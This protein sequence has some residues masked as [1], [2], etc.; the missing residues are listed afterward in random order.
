MSKSPANPSPL[1]QLSEE[2]NLFYST[3]RAF[4]LEK[5]EPLVRSM[6][7]DQQLD[8]D[9]LQ[10][11]FELGLLGIETPEAFGGAGGSFLD[12]KSVV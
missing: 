7:S 1:T 3:V 9:L 5:I 12:R 6:D 10:Q 4:A 8:P 2:E 11:L